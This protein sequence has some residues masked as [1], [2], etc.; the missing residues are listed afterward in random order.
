MTFSRFS[1]P[2]Q[3]GDEI[4]RLL[5]VSEIAIEAQPGVPPAETPGP[6]TGVA[7]TPPPSSPTSPTLPA[8]LSDRI[9]VTRA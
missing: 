4:P 8:P 5:R 2:L 3:E 7:P 6:Q 1:S 9:V